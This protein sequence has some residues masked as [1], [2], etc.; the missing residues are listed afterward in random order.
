MDI[1]K[2]ILYSQLHYIN[3][4]S[5]KNPISDKLKKIYKS[6]Y[7]SLILTLRHGKSGFEY[8]YQKSALI[9]LNKNIVDIILND[10]PFIKW[11]WYP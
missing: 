5:T 6:K 3:H 9:F 11:Q 10:L 4:M 1:L 8:F 2:N 7:F